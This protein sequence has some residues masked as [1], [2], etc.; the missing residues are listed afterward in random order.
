MDRLRAIDVVGIGFPWQVREVWRTDERLLARV[1]ADPDGLLDATTW[2]SLFDAGLSAAPIV[3]P[4]PPR[5]RMPSELRE[6]T[7]FEEPPSEA[8]VSVQLVDVAW[9]GDQVDEVAVDV[10]IARLDGAVVA[11]MHGVRFG[12]VQAAIESE[13][14]DGGVD[15]TGVEWLEIP[16]PELYDHVDTAVRGAVAVELRIEPGELDAHR[17]L[18]EMGADSLLSESIRQRL[19][20]LF[21]TTLPS[22]LLWDRPSIAAVAGYVTET[23][24]LSRTGEEERS[25]A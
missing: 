15:Q 3:F 20:R 25:A 8:L 5:L 17:P 18:S 23:L 11:W 19:N 24:L 14:A 22:T 9:A 4:G 6:V 7:T 21:G 2:G 12:V 16:E 13:S 10:T 1:T